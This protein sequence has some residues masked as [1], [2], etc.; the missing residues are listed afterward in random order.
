M[1]KIFFNLIFL[2]AICYLLFA[3][4]YPVQ[5]A[6]I[7]LW[8]GVSVSCH[9]D[10]EKELPKEQCGNCTLND[11]L[12]FVTNIG[13]LIL[14][15]L[16]VAALIAFIYGGLLW[17]TSGGKS[18]QI[19]QGKRV[20]T[21]AVIGVVIVVFAYVIVYNIMF[22]LGVSKEYYPKTEEKKSC[23]QF[24]SEYKCMDK[25]KCQEETIKIGYCPGPSN[26]VCCIQK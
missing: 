6:K 11:V 16:G 26:I 21:S 13:K 5:A 15:F 9:P 7:D 19:Q 23:S 25:L 14:Q 1:K 8:Q 20:L 24:G 4:C 18:E 17:I 10:C 2:S 3:I 22:W 12:I